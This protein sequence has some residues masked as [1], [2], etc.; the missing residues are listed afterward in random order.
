MNE[1]L[2]DSSSISEVIN[3]FK[4]TVDPD[5]LLYVF[6]KME[7]FCISREYM[8]ETTID[9][10]NQVHSIYIDV[11]QKYILSN[12]LLYTYYKNKKGIWVN[13]SKLKT[14]NSSVEDIYAMCNNEGYYNG[15]IVDYSLIPQ[16]FFTDNTGRRHPIM[17]GDGKG[18]SVCRTDFINEVKSDEIKTSQDSIDKSIAEGVDD[19]LK[20]DIKIEFLNKESIDNILVWMNGIFVDY[21]TKPNVNNI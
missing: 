16:C 19:H 18:Y 8:Y 14:R 13:L 21:E 12:T 17:K 7:P 3:S 4:N 10:K 1:T 20:M 5:S 11:I 2:I 9:S 6:D 15:Y